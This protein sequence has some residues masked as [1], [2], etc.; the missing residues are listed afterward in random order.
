MAHIAHLSICL[1]PPCPPPRLVY[2]AHPRRATLLYVVPEQT[3]VKSEY[4]DDD[5]STIHLDL[6][7]SDLGR[8]ETGI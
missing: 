6:F 2:E 3:F 7:D 4:D 1:H 8:H 5:D